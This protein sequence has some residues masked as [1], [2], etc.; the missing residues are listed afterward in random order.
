MQWCSLSFLPVNKTLSLSLS[1]WVELCNSSCSTY[2]PLVNLLKN[3]HRNVIIFLCMFFLEINY[4][5]NS[6]KVL[7]HKTFEQFKEERN[8][9]TDCSVKK[10]AAFPN[11]VTELFS[12]LL[13][14]VRTDSYSQW[15]SRVKLNMMFRTIHI[16]TLLLQHQEM[17]SLHM[18]TLHF[19]QWLPKHNT[20][21]QYRS[22]AT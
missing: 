10:K 4:L 21:L 3:N 12:M 16:K 17:E 14:P 2:R 6:S 18:A 7:S 13:L 1:L 15:S 19:C 20:A 22:V 8:S 5:K 9:R 11:H